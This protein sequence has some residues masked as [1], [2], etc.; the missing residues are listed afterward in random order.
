MDK[1]IVGM[2]IKVKEDIY[3]WLSDKRGVEGSW[4][5]LKPGNNGKVEKGSILECTDY[6]Q[7]EFVFEGNGIS[8]DGRVLID[9]GILQADLEYLMEKGILK[10]VE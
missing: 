3:L 1:K 10:E 5:T 7:N 4:N 6:W 8:H 2:K 9:M